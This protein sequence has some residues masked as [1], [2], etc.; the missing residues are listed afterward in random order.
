MTHN[1]SHLGNLSSSLKANIHLSQYF[2]YFICISSPRIQV[3]PQGQY[4]FISIFPLFHMHLTHKDP[5]S[6]S[7]LIFINLYISNI[8]LCISSPRIQVPPQGQ[9]ANILTFS[10]LFFIQHLITWG[11]CFPSRQIFK[12]LSIP[13]NFF[14]FWTHGCKSRR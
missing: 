11:P 6:I 8:F 1:W 10:T 14:K 13:Y 2:H 3:P 12:Y 4:S 7:R 9:Y 5:S